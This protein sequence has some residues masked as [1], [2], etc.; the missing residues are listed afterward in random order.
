[1]V[2]SPGTTGRAGT[3]RHLLAGSAA[4]VVGAAVQA[5]SGAVFWLVA[6]RIDTTDD[7]GRA[8][9]LFT[10]ILFI[11]Y[12][13]GLGL[14]VS[15]ARFAPGRD[16]ESHAVFS[17]GVLA[18]VVS[19]AVVG[20]GYLLAVDTEATR[21]LTDWHA[22]GGPVLFVL[23]AVGAAL[24]LIVDVRWMTVRRWGLV[25]ARITVVG[26]ARFPLLLLPAG[27]HHTVHLFAV[28]AI[29]LVLTGV[30]GVVAMPWVSGLRHRLR[31]LPSTRRAAIR[32]SAVNY[33]STL[34]YQAPQF[35]LP[36]IVL[37]SV[38]PDT[39]AA[40]YV[41]WGIT[42]IVLYV[43]MA[44]GQALLAEGGKDG[45]E[46]RSQVRVALVLTTALMAAAAIVATVGRDLL[47]VVY[48]DD[49]G[50]AARILPALVVCGLPWAITSVYLTEARVMH[51]HVP[52]VLITGTL[53][54]AILAPALVLVP[55]DGVDGATRAFLLG[56][57]V[58]AGVALA[59]HRISLRRRIVAVPEPGSVEEGLALHP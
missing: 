6:A 56:N 44:I 33:V 2:A 49:Y 15:L 53:T 52:T 18:T 21:A 37:L 58:A 30:G 20:A 12:L 31:P 57:L 10:S 43:P 24:T 48:G 42:A 25:L 14:Q 16:E 39:N 1:M 59:S 11:A 50:D 40:F 46:L 19:A 17:W 28:A 41:A 47:T 3:H 4:L 8:T 23:G 35:V 55:D 5:L 7:V 29:P 54:V 51:W 22:V 45:A 38:D 36:V 9:A 32:Y 26:I 34:A 27:E 13:A